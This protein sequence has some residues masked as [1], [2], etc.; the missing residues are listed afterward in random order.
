MDITDIP[1]RFAES[2]F[3]QF[4]CRFLPL[5]RAHADV[6]LDVPSF[7]IGEIK[8]FMKDSNNHFLN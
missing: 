4:S 2:P 8:G 1:T 7:G 5:F 3:F 6:L